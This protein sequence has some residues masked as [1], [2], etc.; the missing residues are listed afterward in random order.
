MCCVSSEARLLLTPSKNTV[1]KRRGMNKSS[2]AE[3]MH[4][5]RIAREAARLHTPIAF[6]PALL[7]SDFT[8]PKDAAY[9]GSAWSKRLS[10]AGSCCRWNKAQR[11]GWGLA[12]PPSAAT[13]P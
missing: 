9:A 5:G 10:P 11:D 3:E 6:D 1:R 7:A 4:P 12:A 2:K 13:R 8:L